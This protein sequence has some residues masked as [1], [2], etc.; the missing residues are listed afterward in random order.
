MSPPEQVGIAALKAN[1][2]HFLRAV[3]RGGTVTV[4]DR[5]VPVARIVPQDDEAALLPSTPP[6][7]GIH[8]VR[9]PSARAGRR[10]DSLAALLEERQGER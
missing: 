7:R 4:L 9:L 6:S 8:D 5:G 10:V 2:S 3:R 1:L